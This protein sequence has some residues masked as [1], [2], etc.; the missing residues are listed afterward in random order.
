MPGS[1]ASAPKHPQE[2]WQSSRLR[3]GA[4]SEWEAWTA[5]GA[6]RSRA[7]SRSVAAP[8]GR[9][10]R[11]GGLGGARSPP[12]NRSPQGVGEVGDE[13]VHVLDPDR[14]PDQIVLDADLETFLS[15]ELV[16]AHD[17]WLFD[18]ALHA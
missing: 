8:P 16:K 18:E 6:P 1:L 12:F 5:S 7:R 13:I 4:K 10:E 3:R 9:D 15:G 11:P 14:V 2:I 17:R